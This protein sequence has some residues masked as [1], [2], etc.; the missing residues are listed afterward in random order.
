MYEKWTRIR[1]PK[2]DRPYNHLG[3]NTQFDDKNISD[4]L[5]N[6]HI[7][8]QEPPVGQFDDTWKTHVDCALVS[9]V[10]KEK[11]VLATHT[12]QENYNVEI[13]AH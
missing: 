10:A 9:Y 3:T 13:M 5:V 6:T 8:K 12:Q 1:T 7:T 11:E 4:I 2:S